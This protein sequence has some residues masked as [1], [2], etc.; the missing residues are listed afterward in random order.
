MQ[1][2][3]CLPAKTV[4][5]LCDCNSPSIQLYSLLSGF[6]IFSTCA[7]IRPCPNRTIYM[8]VFQDCAH[9]DTLPNHYLHIFGYVL[10]SDACPNTIID[11]V[12]FFVLLLMC[13]HQILAQTAQTMNAYHCLW[14][15]KLVYLCLPLEILQ[16]LSTFVL[17]V[18]IRHLP[19]L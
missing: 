4:H 18:C 17:Y 15:R 10:A 11:L 14:I 19:E 2:A 3:Q 9:F 13:F 5:S 12:F 16:W 8:I 1:F 7:C 6:L